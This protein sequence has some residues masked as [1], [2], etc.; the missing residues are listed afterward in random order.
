MRAV[1]TTRSSCP[2]TGSSTGRATR[3]TRSASGSDPP[4]SV[5]SVR[6]DSAVKAQWLDPKTGEFTGASPID[7]VYQVKIPAGTKV[8]PGPVGNMGGVYVGGGNQIFV[9]TPWKID[10]VDV[11][12][13]E[14]LP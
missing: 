7:T 9:P 3:R 12:G 10:G 13:S 8:F 1:A 14:P 6:I 4:Q 5:A 2:R 11:L